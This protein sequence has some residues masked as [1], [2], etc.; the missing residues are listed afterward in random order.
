MKK[1]KLIGIFIFATAVLFLG[2]CD[3]NKED[4]GSQQDNIEVR[5]I[6]QICCGNMMTTEN[7]L[8][9]SPCEFYEDSLLRAVNIDEFAIA[10]NYQFGDLLTIKFELTEACEASCE[11]T[12][13]RMNGVPIKILSVE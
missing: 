13:N 8:V 5:Y 6:E 10:Q 4:S 7:H 11:L 1:S 3:K 9:A 12:C 2:A